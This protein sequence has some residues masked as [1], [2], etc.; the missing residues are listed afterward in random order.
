MKLFERFK[1]NKTDNPS[2]KIISDKDDVRHTKWA[3]IT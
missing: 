3:L 1:K 2:E